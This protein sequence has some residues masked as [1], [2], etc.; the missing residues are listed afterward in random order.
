MNNEHV[1][2]KSNRSDWDQDH[3]DMP[4]RP[5]YLGLGMDSLKL[6]LSF[7]VISSFIPYVQLTHQSHE[8]LFIYC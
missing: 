7:G 8:H 2:K 6:D 4:Q 5:Q 3:R 1:C